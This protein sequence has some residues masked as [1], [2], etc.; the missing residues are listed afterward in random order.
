LEE[1]N[2][3]SRLHLRSSQKQRRRIMLK[4]RVK[5]GKVMTLRKQTMSSH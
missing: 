2:L 5:K 4:K 1:R 3:L